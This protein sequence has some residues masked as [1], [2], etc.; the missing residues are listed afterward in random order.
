MSTR[1]G[2]FG[3]TFDPP[4]LAHLILAEEARQQLALDE[5]VFMPTGQPWMKAPLSISPADLRLE[6]V[7]LATTSNPF[8]WVSPL[9][10]E[11]AGPTYTVDTLV[12]LREL[13]GPEAELFFLLGM[14]SLKLLPG[15]R[16]PDRVLQLCT[17]V[18]FARPDHPL[19]SLAEVEA[20]LPGLRERVQLVQGPCLGISGTEIRRRAS[21][22]LSIRYLVPPAVGR[23]IQAHGLY[24]GEAGR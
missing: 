12:A 18:A 14:D 13:W 1:I 19:S 16:E 8:F 24:R 17:F 4:H 15:W 9:E 5:V 20:R 21:E 22:G 10:V 23:V 6:M 3:G 2:I 11:R 7:R